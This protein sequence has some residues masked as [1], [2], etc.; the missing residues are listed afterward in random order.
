MIMIYRTLR[1]RPARLA[2]GLLLA[3]G[4]AAAADPPPKDQPPPRKTDA[5]LLVGTWQLLK[6]GNQTFDPDGY[7]PRLEF[8]AKGELIITK[9][10]S[11]RPNPTVHRGTYAVEGKTIKI[12][13]P[14]Q[15]DPGARE[16]EW[17]IDRLDGET[18]ELT[19][20]KPPPGAG[21]KAVLR[22][23]PAK[24]ADPKK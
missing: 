6:D 21:R 11:P 13:L 12:T 10:K 5:E 23:L 24:G 22:R 2:A 17:V 18:F 3:A 4:V 15:D 1:S 20:A 19:T 7:H 14:T 16:H 8:T 9:H